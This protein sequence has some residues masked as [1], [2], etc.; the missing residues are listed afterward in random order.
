MCEKILHFSRKATVDLG[1]KALAEQ[2]ER[3]SKRKN[4]SILDDLE[5]IEEEVPIKKEVSKRRQV[6]L[7]LMREL[8]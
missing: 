5:E 8:D 4:F 6:S 1:K 7:D 2:K 3:I